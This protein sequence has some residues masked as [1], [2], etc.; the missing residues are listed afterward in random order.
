MFC[1]AGADRTG[2]GRCTVPSC[3]A[4]ACCAAVVV[5]F[6]FGAAPRQ[7]GHPT[8]TSSAFPAAVA[9]AAA[10]TRESGCPH[11]MP[12]D[13]WWAREWR[14]RA[15][16]RC[17]ALAD[18]GWIARRRR[19]CRRHRRRRRE[20]RISRG[21]SLRGHNTVD[22]SDDVHDEVG[23]GTM[24]AEVALGRGDNR[25]QGTGVCWRCKLL[26][27]KV[28]PTGSAAGDQLAA[29]IT[30]AADNGADVI[31]VE[32][33]VERARRRGRAVRWR[34]RR[35]VALWWWR[36]PGNDGGTTA[37]YP[38]SYRGVI[39]VVGVDQNTTAR[40]P[41]RRGA[42]GPGSPRRAAPSSPTRRQGDELLRQLRR[43]TG[44]VGAGRAPAFGRDPARPRHDHAARVRRPQ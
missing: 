26:P 19:R 29:G 33:G 23:H 22:G 39:G 18:D 27:V 3:S 17:R 40:T 36:P 44:R 41:G 2:I 35:C 11:G 4:A 10:R 30:W 5:F 15:D 14:P 7:P 43:G 31:N 1:P 24:V 32:P 12:A 8:V 37:S 9:G 34:T 28:A 21:A 38:A 20:G 13:P 42:P 25:R 16:R 6:S